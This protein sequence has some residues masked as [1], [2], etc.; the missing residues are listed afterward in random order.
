MQRLKFEM[1]RFKFAMPRF[2]FETPQIKLPMQRLK[3]ETPRFKFAMPRFKL[4][5]PQIKFAM[6]RFKFDS[7]RFK[8]KTPCFRATMP[9]CEKEIPRFS[10]KMRRCLQR[11]RHFDRHSSRKNFPLSKILPAMIRKVLAW[12]HLLRA[13]GRDTFTFCLL[14]EMQAYSSISYARREQAANRNG[15]FQRDFMCQIRH[16]IRRGTCCMQGRWRNAALSSGT[17][18]NLLHAALLQPAAVSIL[19]AD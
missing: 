19:I 13:T 8:F 1:P 14:Q 5:T 18:Y 4:E 17:G 16:C 7:P 6:R 10:R 12:A 2:K 9:R 3:F 15:Q 11:T